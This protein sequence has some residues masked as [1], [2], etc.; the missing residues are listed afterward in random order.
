MYNGAVTVVS[1]IKQEGGTKSFRLAHLTIRLLTFCNWTRIVIIAVHI[2]GHFN[3]QANGLSRPGQT[4]PIE[5]EIDHSLLDPVFRQWGQ[6]WID[7]FVTYCN[8]KYQQFVSPYLD[9]R[10]TI[11]D[12]ILILWRQ[13]GTVYAFPP[14]KIPAVIAKLRQSH[15]I[16]MILIALYLMTTSWMTELLQ[17]SSHG[18][19]TAHLV[20]LSDGGAETGHT[21]AQIY[22]C[23]NS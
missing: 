18:S 19:E 23:G 2:L 12:A 7:L 13:M 10:A 6:P 16:T 4:L 5:W 22:T 3:M 17:L 11:T 15:A 20:H 14:F 8:H 1:Y 9:P 21:T